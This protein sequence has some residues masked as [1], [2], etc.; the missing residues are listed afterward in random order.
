M[1]LAQHFT[2]LQEQDL[3]NLASTPV[4]PPGT[5]FHPTFTTL[6][7]PVNSEN[8]SRVYLSNRAYNRLRLALL[9]VI[10]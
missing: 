6:L 10:I 4:Q 1:P 9:N 2:F 3:E 7:T 8:D 5:L